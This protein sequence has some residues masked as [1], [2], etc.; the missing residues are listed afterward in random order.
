MKFES[1]AVATK[2]DELRFVAKKI[3]ELIVNSKEPLDLS[4]ICI[5]SYDQDIYALHAREIFREYGIPANITDRA[6]L[7]HAPLYLAFGALFELG[8]YNF[9]RRAIL[10]LLGSPY[11]LIC[12]PDGVKVNSANLYHVITE[13]RL[14]QGAISWCEEIDVYLEE[15]VQRREQ[16]LDQYDL[17]DLAERHAKLLEAKEDIGIIEK[18]LDKLR[19]DKTP[20]EFCDQ[21]RAIASE[22]RLTQQILHSSRPMIA[23]QELEFDTRSYRAFMDLLDEL[24]ATCLRLGLEKTKLGFSFYTERIRIAALATRFSPRA[25]PGRGVIITSFD[26]TLG[27]NF[28]HL[29]L[30]GLNDSVFPEIYSPS[31]FKLR[32]H[33]SGEDESLIEQRYLFYQTL[34]T[35]TSQITLMR[36]RS[37]DDRKS[38]IMQ[39]QFA[40]ALLLLTNTIEIETELVTDKIYSANEF[41]RYAAHSVLDTESVASLGQAQGLDQHS[42]ETLRMQIPHSVALAKK[43][44]A[45]PASEFSGVLPFDELTESERRSLLDFQSRVYSISQLETYAICPFRFFSKYVLKLQAGLQKDTEEGMSPSER[46][47]MLH[48]TLYRILTGLRERGE[49]LRSLSEEEFTRLGREILSEPGSAAIQPN[50]PFRKLDL[51]SVFEPPLPGIGILRKFIEAERE[52]ASFITKPAFFEATFGLKIS[53]DKRDKSLYRPEPVEIGGIKFR[54]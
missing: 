10:R 34:S 18:L 23:L 31:L 48:D 6:R 33:Q 7:D 32:E 25:E 43:R 29:F 14:R 9:G 45:T 24:L 4:N 22:C 38:Q 5:A 1:F 35:A 8:E 40:E 52:Y 53:K 20:A 36:H 26:Q 2:R 12:R 44:A 39:S 42:L 13:Y 3:K 47:I 15:I 16:V 27:Y 49:E 11:L 41:F 19:G 21:V 17:D 46:G 54:G 51:E 37:S 30:L 28:E 50:H